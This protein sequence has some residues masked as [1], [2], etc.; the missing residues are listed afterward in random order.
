MVSHPQTKKGDWTLLKEETDLD[1]QK[2]TLEMELIT[3]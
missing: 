3:L 1:H 2:K